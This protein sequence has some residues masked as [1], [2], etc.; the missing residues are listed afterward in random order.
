MKMQLLLLKLASKTTLS[1]MIKNT[2]QLKYYLSCYF[3]SCLYLVDDIK[4]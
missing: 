3:I 2:L 4:T 1:D